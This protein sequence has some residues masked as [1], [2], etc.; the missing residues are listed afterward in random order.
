VDFL[1]R[2]CRH[3]RTAELWTIDG[4]TI[5]WLGV[6]LFAAGGALRIWPVFVL[7]NDLAA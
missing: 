7:A 5:R 2:I 4:D 1:R 6:V 3:T